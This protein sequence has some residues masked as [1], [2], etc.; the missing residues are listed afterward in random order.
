M[1][2]NITQRVN[3]NTVFT[4]TS[5]TQ[6]LC[7]ALLLRSTPLTLS[8][9]LGGSRY[10]LLPLPILACLL[11]GLNLKGNK[12]AL[13]ENRLLLTSLAAFYGWIWVCAGFSQHLKTAV[14]YNVI[15]TT[16]G[17]IF[18]GFLLITANSRTH[19]SIYRL[20][21]YFLGFL[22]FL[23]TLEFFC[24]ELWIFNGLGAYNRHYPQV[25][26]LTVNPNP[27]GALMA[28]A[29]GFSIVLKKHNLIKAYEF[30]PVIFLILT[31][32]TFAAS[33]NGWLVFALFMLLGTACRVLS[34]REALAYSFAALFLALFFPN[35][36]YRLGFG[37]SEFFP[38]LNLV[39]SVLSHYGVLI[40]E[41][42]FRSLTSSDPTSTALSRFVLWKAAIAQIIEHPITGIGTGVFAQ[43]IGP[44]IIVRV[45]LHS[46]KLFL[47]LA[48]DTGLPG[49]LLFL[50]FLTRVIRRAALS[51]R[52]AIIFLALLLTSQLP[53]FFVS[54]STFM[55]VS[56]YF[57][58]IACNKSLMN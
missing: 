39:D 12:K 9:F 50:S 11:I 21:F 24:P 18:I 54:D 57:F 56:A 52:V 43:H 55:V 3:L 30:Y 1:E 5:R 47:N 51:N 41:D 42:S 8:L 6:N 35:P 13:T 10:N 25:M 45:C 7:L 32:L 34:F 19:Q 37:E 53:D 38:L 44:Q 48:A 17:L 2:A 36:A 22:A 46:H 49:L 26:S 23:G 15:Y 33:R 16:Y 20:L 14:K 4:K 29:A 31:A 27:F 28:I 40:P 58:A